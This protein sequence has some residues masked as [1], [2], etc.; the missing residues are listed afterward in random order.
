[1]QAPMHILVGTALS[2]AAPSMVWELASEL[3]QIITQIEL[4][5]IETVE[6]ARHIVASHQSGT[7]YASLPKGRPKTLDKII[8]EGPGLRERLL[9]LAYNI[10]KEHIRILAKAGRDRDADTAL[11]LYYPPLPPPGSQ[12][13]PSGSALDLLMHT[14]S[15]T[16]RELYDSGR[17]SCHKLET[18]IQ[19]WRQT[20]MKEQSSH[21]RVAYDEVFERVFPSR[22]GSVECLLLAK[23]VERLVASTKKLRA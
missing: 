8:Q 17:E 1:M 22:L 3:V 14:F 20:Y 12:P 9:A 23:N 18:K 5:R 21:D 16:E 10:K 15:E 6:D 4:Y 2:I 19:K 13:P 11:L 7:E